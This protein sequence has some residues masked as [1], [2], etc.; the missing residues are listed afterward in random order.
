MDRIEVKS[1]GLFLPAFAD[2][3]VGGEA[4]EGFES[5]GEVIS[6]NEVSKVCAELRVIVVV[7]ALH[8]GFLN[9]S[10]HAFDLPVGPGMVGFGEAVID[11]VQKAGPVKRMA[12]KACGWALAV[13]GQIGEL[14]AVIGKHGV[15]V[16]GNGCNQSLKKCRRGAHVSTFNQFHEG[17]LRGA[18]DGHEQIQLAFCGAYLGQIDMKVADRITLELLPSISGRR[19]MS[20][21]S[22]QRCRE[23]R[24]SAG[25]VACSA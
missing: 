17:E 21:R 13:L 19:L 23:E 25:M 10:V 7:V 22:R 1:V 18:V 15:D 5:L 8:G 3:F 4:F 9:G 14:D 12:T 16:I 24:V 20:C 6:R 11:A 2:E